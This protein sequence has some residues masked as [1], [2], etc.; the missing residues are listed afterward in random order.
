MANSTAKITVLNPT[1]SSSAAGGLLAA[2]PSTLK[3]T[4]LGC[5]WNNQ[6]SADR[7]L[8]GVAQLLTEK[9]EL[10]QIIYRKKEY[11]GEPA[12][13]KLID[14]LATACDVVITALGN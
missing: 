6:V 7:I 3:G 13:E 14:E 10:S 12:S 5:L 8:A 1:I 9:Y 11:V 2:R 4:T